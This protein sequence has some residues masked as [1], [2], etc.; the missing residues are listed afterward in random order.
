[1][2]DWL[3]LAALA[4][5]ALRKDKAPLGPPV[6]KPNPDGTCP[7][8]YNGVVMPGN[9]LT[10]VRADITPPPGHTTETPATADSWAEALE[11]AMIEMTGKA[12]ESFGLLAGSLIPIP[13]AGE[14]FGV[15][16]GA[17]GELVGE[18]VTTAAG[19]VA[20]G[21]EYVWDHTGGAVLDYFGL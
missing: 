7:V 9:A 17:V 2:K 5:F 12:G 15:I 16:G 11:G 1:M 18:V 14:F 10:C 13:G 21:A 8:G 19:Y 4:L 6:V 20:E 3:P